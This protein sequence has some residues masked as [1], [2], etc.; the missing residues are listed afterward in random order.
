MERNGSDRNEEM[1]WREGR[2]GGGVRDRKCWERFEK[3]IVM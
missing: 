2:V 3:K 1:R